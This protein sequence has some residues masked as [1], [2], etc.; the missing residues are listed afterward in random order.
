[1]ITGSNGFI[2]Q[3]LLEGLLRIGTFEIQATS[4]GVDRYQGPGKYTYQSLDVC[5][6]E[7]LRHTLE[8][9]TPQVL[10]HTVALAQVDYCEQHPEAAQALN[11]T[12]LRHLL[13]V[14]KEKQ[15]KLLFLSTDF[16][17]DGQHGPYREGDQTN[18]LNVYGHSKREAEQYIQESEIEW[19]I[20]RTILVYGLPHDSQR[21]N[22]I[23]WVKRELEQGKSLDIVCDQY[24]MP[25]LVED[26]VEACI[27]LIIRG[28]TGLFHISG[29][30][31][32]SIYDLACKV[33]QFWGLDTS[34]LKAVKAQHLQERVRRPSY[35]GFILDKAQ[36]ELDY[37]PHTMEE[38]LRLMQEQM[39][40][41][42]QG[43]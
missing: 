19:A 41:R 37:Q 22:M 28:K 39:P 25:T 29:P 17:F 6:A 18:P 27:A 33:A 26:L 9:F 7:A 12:P 36:K 5:D 34:A 31:L 40:E 3:K 43:Y 35:T 14:C 24:R 13:D 1:M 8:R 15:I 4:R 23:L 30:E 10:I 2:G 21:S 11:V 20:I 32:F 16:V 42:N 38:G